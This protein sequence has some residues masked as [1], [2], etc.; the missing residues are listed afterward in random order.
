MKEKKTNYEK[1][2]LVVIELDDDI[3]LNSVD[4]DYEDLF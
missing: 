4:V 1:P 3:T 2:E